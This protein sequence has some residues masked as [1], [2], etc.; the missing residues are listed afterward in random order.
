MSSLLLDTNVI[1]EGSKSRP[2]PA[3]AKMMRTRNDL[4]LSVV[5][6][7]E[8]EYGAAIIKDIPYRDRLMVSITRLVSHFSG[9]ILPVSLQAAEFAALL[10]AQAHRLG[11]VLKPAD[12][13]I[14]GTAV[15]HNLTLATRNIKD[16][17]DLDVDIFNPWDD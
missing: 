2:H 16:F 11:R 4:W 17:A 3:V 14:A 9:R 8:M 6:I 7:H 15:A 10:R 5:V 13:L 1:S 12:A